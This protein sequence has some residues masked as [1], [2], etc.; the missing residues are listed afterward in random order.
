MSINKNKAISPEW[1]KPLHLRYTYMTS[2]IKVPPPKKKVDDAVRPFLF[3]LDNSD[4]CEQFNQYLYSVLYVNSVNRP[5]TVYDQVNPVGPSFALI[6]DTFANVP[7]VNFVDS[8]VPNAS[9]LNQHDNTRV[10]PFINT[11]RQE[12]LQTAAVGILEWNESMLK[13]ISVLRTQYNI[14]DMIDVGV[15]MTQPAGSRR[16]DTAFV[17]NSYINT[18]TDVDNRLSNP[19]VLNVFIASNDSALLQDFIIRAKSS[20]KI[21]MIPQ[22]TVSGFS[23][24][25]FDRQQARVRLQAYKEFIAILSCLQTSE[26]LITS[27]SNE[28]GKFLFMTNTTM[29]YFKSMESTKFVAR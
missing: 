4:F 17:V 27:F 1:S 12:D 29:T 3:K 15:Y 20:W 19:P 24:A 11:I 18:V 16:D 22:L 6:K 21:H 7:G 26:N 14:P 28:V 5:L 8:M 25:S 2:W 10:I 13:D 23:V 9:T